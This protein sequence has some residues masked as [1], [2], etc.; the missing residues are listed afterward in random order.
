MSR[1]H[2]AIN[3]WGLFF[4]LL[5]TAGCLDA[6]LT[7][8]GVTEGYIISSNGTTPSM[9]AVVHAADEFRIVVANLLWIKVVDHYHHQFLA[10]GG[11]WNHNTALM[12]YLRMIVWLDPHFIE[13]YEVGGSI[14]AATH[15]YKDCDDYLGQGTRSNLNSWQL[16]YDRAMLHAWYEKSPSSALPFAQHALDSAT[17]PFDHQRIRRFCDTLVREEEQPVEIR[18]LQTPTAS[19]SLTRRIN[20]RD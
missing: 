17:D 4:V 12:P 7:P 6:S 20:D 3:C 11:A 19:N 16:Y 10:K 8:L 1:R 15:R 18:G 14:L 2:S 13:A 9:E 5:I